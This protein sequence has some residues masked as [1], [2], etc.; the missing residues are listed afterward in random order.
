MSSGF[1]RLQGHAELL[2]PENDN[3]DNTS[4]ILM[5]ISHFDGLEQCFLTISTN[6][7]FRAAV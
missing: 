2:V 6:F 7:P 5:L 4:V 3:S 1:E